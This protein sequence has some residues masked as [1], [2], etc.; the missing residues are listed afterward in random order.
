MPTP[1]TITDYADRIARVADDI[2][3]H[4]D[5]PLDLERL[6]GIACFSPF[7]FTGSTTP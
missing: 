4:Q 5:E 2:G 3:E 6:A 7:H 1:N